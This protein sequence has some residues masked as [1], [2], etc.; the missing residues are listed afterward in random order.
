[1][2]WKFDMLHFYDKHHPKYFL[3][4]QR[5]LGAINAAVSKRLQHTLKWNRSQ[6]KRRERKK[7]SNGLADGICR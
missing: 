1:M 3:I 7:Y 5:L 6:S 2:H 4:W